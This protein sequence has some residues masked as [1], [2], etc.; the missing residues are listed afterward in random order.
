[1]AVSSLHCVDK[2]ELTIIM[3]TTKRLLTVFLSPTVSPSS[4]LAAGDR[5]LPAII[6]REIFA[7]EAWSSRP[8]TSPVR[9][10]ASIWI[11]A[12]AGDEEPISKPDTTPIHSSSAPED[13]MVAL[14]IRVS[15]RYRQEIWERAG[16]WIT[17][18]RP[19]YHPHL[20]VQ[21]PVVGLIQ[22]GRYQLP[23]NLHSEFPTP[24]RPR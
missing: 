22:L 3:V 4:V 16:M 24:R 2:D 17:H 7:Q 23:G 14:E 6:R 13:D 18:H 11:G 10:S 12:S 15:Y 8:P 21:C 1:M 19:P 5:Q 9:Y 20:L